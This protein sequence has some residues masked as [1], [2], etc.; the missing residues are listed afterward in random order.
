MHRYSFNER[1]NP[2][3]PATQVQSQAKAKLNLLERFCN[4]FP[5]H[6]SAIWPARQNLRMAGAA[7]HSYLP[8]VL[9]GNEAGNADRRR[10]SQEPRPV[11]FFL[12]HPRSWPI[13]RQ[14]FADP[15]LVAEEIEFFNL[16]VKIYCDQSLKWVP[17]ARSSA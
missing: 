17:R 5:Q 3:P 7:G 4:W 6:V 8:K 1:F 14:G 2:A 15:L 11:N 9:D 16:E 12:V 13:H 10:L